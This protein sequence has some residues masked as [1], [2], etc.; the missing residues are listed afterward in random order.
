VHA[1]QGA[2]EAWPAEFFP[3]LPWGTVPMQTGAEAARLRGIPSIKDCEFTIAGFVQP[4][5]LPECERLGMKAILAAPRNKPWFGHHA[6]LSDSQID[7]MV[8]AQVKTAGTSPA[9]LGYYIMDEPGAQHFP[10]LAKAVAAVKKYAPGKLAYINLFPGYATIGAPNQS[11]LGSKSFTEYLEHYIAEVRPQFLSYD[12]YM[13]QY[14][15]DLHSSER[16]AR[17]YSDLMEVRRVAL[18]HGLT[19][20]N[21]VSS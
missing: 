1:Q 8:R 7:E 18:E 12:N 9:I 20:W 17:Y 4:K 16:G 14:S 3:I 6:K 13:V 2:V 21:I 19:F 15:Q 10:M 5:D 11:Q